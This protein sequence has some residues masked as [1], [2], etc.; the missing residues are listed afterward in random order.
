MSNKKD[1]KS[2]AGHGVD[3]ATFRA[4]DLDRKVLAEISAQPGIA[5]LDVGCGLGGQSLRMARAGARVI[6]IDVIDVSERFAKTCVEYELKSE[7]LDFNQ[8]SLEQVGEHF[9]SASFGAA[10]VQ[11]VLHYVPY[12]VARQFLVDLR[13]IVSGRLYIS[14]T[15]NGSA[16][17][18]YCPKCDCSIVERFGKLSSEGQD[19][20]S[21]TEP[22]CIYSES[23]LR[24]LLQEAGWHVEELWVSQFGNIKAVCA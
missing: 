1:Y 15:G 22:I 7:A 14:V 23:E 5:V 20:F 13:R 11:R 6:G 3:V 4:D 19:L 18:R 24:E 12:E 17:A 9:L 10:V 8:L 16:I 21:I 2:I